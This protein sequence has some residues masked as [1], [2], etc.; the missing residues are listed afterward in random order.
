MRLSTYLGNPLKPDHPRSGS[1]F[2]YLIEGVLHI[3]PSNHR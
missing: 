3:T 1:E 2:L